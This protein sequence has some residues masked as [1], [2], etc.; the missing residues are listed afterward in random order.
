[1]LSKPEEGVEC[2]T[3]CANGI[4]EAQYLL[5]KEM[6]E[7]CLQKR[8]FKHR[9]FQLQNPII[10]EKNHRVIALILRQCHGKE[11][12]NSVNETLDK[13]RSRCWLVWRRQLIRTMLGNRDICR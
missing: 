6:N 12:H 11:I 8:V 2:V 7:H 9:K 1:M 4:D 5:A 3:S 13:V 10:L